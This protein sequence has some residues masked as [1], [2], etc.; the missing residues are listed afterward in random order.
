M[1]GSR[2]GATIPICKKSVL[3][4]RCIKSMLCLQP[5]L[6]ESNKN[7]FNTDS[8]QNEWLLTAFYVATPKDSRITKA[9]SI[10]HSFDDF[11]KLVLTDMR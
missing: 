6:K 9:N 7:N 10:L 11:L 8:A 4:L 3:L 2:K 1:C 5:T